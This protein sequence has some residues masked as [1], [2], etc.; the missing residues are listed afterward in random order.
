M[1]PGSQSSYRAAMSGTGADVGG[2]ERDDEGPIAAGKDQTVM[3]YRRSLDKEELDRLI[4]GGVVRMRLASDGFPDDVER[5][6]E[7]SLRDLGFAVMQQMVLEAAMSIEAT[8][9][10]RITEVE[11]HGPFPQIVEVRT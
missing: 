8:D 9:A 10:V 2:G 5:F 11:A 1:K 6:V 4:R 3:T 7:F